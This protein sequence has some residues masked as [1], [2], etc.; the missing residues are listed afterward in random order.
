M[1][2]AHVA[3]FYGPQ[4]GG[5]RT[6]MHALGRGYVERGH[7]YLMVVPGSRNGDTYAAYGQRVTLASPRLPRSGG[8]RVITRPALVRDLLEQYQPD[9]IE[10][11]DRTT[12]RGLGAWGIAQ[13]IQTVFFAHERAEDAVR[14]HVPRAVAA[15]LPL[16][17][18]ANAHHR[19][20]YQEFSHIVCTT[21][22]AA[23]EFDRIHAPVT[24]VPLGV[25]L[26]QF[27]PR[28]SSSHVRRRYAAHDELLVV[29]ASRLSAE[30]R[31]D[32][33]IDA[34]G[35]LAATGVR[36]RLVIAG[37]GAEE[38]ALR[39]RA[40]RG[41]VTFLGFTA[42]RLA[43][44]RLLATA[45][46]VVAPGPIETFGLAALEAL[47]SGTP[48]VVNSASALPEVVG[49]AGVAAGG[50][51]GEFASAILELASDPLAGDRARKRAECFPWS[52]TVDAMVALH[53]ARDGALT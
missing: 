52:A 17:T 14:A 36:V 28:W 46:V 2:I 3:N 11:S 39:E 51:A 40:P 1:R 9:A 7:D 53:M 41:Q 23:A 29:M 18:L 24:T 19:R 47:A 15:A 42:D 50:T 4:S 13:G 12:L 44:A 30:K 8:Y 31:C 35:L 26:E 32:L 21:G 34:V 38:R 27:H 48:T 22:Y 43:L 25:D 45:D 6:T 10:V 5:L 20:I 49:T 16:H 33:A 37:A